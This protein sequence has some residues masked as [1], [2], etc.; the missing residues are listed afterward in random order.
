LPH[1]ELASPA[2]AHALQGRPGPLR[3]MCAADAAHRQLIQAVACSAGQHRALEVHAAAQ[4]PLPRGDG[5]GPAPAHAD[6]KGQR[7]C[8]VPG[9]CTP[10]NRVPWLLHSK[11]TRPWL[12][13][14]KQPRPLAAALQTNAS[15]WLLHSRQTR[16]RGCGTLNKCVP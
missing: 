3:S 2:H 4:V 14:S 9:C 15:P 16:H 1:T 8:G 6:G 7:E 12:L 10:N 13:H 5:S 11:E